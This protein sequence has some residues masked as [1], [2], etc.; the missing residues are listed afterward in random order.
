MS[1][2]NQ[3][4]AV[5]VSLLS[6]LLIGPWSTRAQDPATKPSSPPAQKKQTRRV[7]DYFG[8][9]GLTP[10][11]KNSIYAVVD[12]RREK[13]EALEKQIAAERAEMLTEC[14]AV[15]NETQKKLLDNLRKAAD[16]PKPVPTTKPTDPPKTSK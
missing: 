4:G 14:E 3:T 7:P 12:R 8:Q 5:A 6:V 2:R 10:E 1:I 15:L 9:I 13:I 16:E 11:Q